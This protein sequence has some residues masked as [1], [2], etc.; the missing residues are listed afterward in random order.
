MCIYASLIKDD[1]YFTILEKS[2][3]HNLTENYSDTHH[4]ECVFFFF[5]FFFCSWTGSPVGDGGRLHF[6]LH[7]SLQA[8]RLR[9]RYG[10]VMIFLHNQ[11][12]ILLEC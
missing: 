8:V 9:A 10:K 6:R 1:V 3:L 11:L 12:F 5:V 7:S 4:S 2:C